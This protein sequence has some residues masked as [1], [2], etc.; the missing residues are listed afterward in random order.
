MI[1]II[2]AKTARPTLRG[3][4]PPSPSTFAPPSETGP[5]FGSSPVSV[6]GPRRGAAPDIPLASV[7]PEV[8]PLPAPLLAARLVS[9]M[10][11]VE[12][13]LAGRQVSF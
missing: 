5:P 9:T 7:L 11:N 2:S 13:A 4:L 1:A 12:R 6:A 8:I 3:C 10:G